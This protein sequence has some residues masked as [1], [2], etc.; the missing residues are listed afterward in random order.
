MPGVSSRELRARTRSPEQVPHALV[1][2]CVRVP[3]TPVS[4]PSPFPGTALK[5]LVVH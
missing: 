2:S 3:T 1:F 4:S 5:E